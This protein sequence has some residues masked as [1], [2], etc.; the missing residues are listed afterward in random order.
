MDTHNTP[1]RICYTVFTT[2]GEW[3]YLFDTNVANVKILL[4]IADLNVIPILEKFSSI[5]SKIFSQI[6]I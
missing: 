1:I 3:T 4:D 2:V 5:M 6:K